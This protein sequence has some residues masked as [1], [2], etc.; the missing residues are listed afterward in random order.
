MTFE[1][2]ILVVGG[3]LMGL[4][5]GLLSV[6]S[7]AIVPALRSLNA[8]QHL[9][10]MQAINVKIVNAVFLIIFFGPQ[11]PDAAGGVPAPDAL[12]LA[13]CCASYHRGERRDHR[14]KCAP[15]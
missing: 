9:A 10:A 4:L 11:R 7:F 14:R 5:A 12:T 8:K 1:N 13:G 2:T 3:T 15:E 6:F